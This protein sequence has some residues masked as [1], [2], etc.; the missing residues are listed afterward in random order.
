MTPSDQD[1]MDVKIEAALA[2]MRAERWG[3]RLWLALAVTAAGV[4][5]AVTLSFCP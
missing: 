3:E 4:I 5:V 2:R 1:L